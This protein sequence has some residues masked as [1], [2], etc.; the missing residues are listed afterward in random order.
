MA[1]D[2]EPRL[3]VARVGTLVITHHRQAP[4]LAYARRECAYLQ[5]LLAQIGRPAT[6][7]TLPDRVLPLV[8][9]EVLEVYRKPAEDTPIAAWAAVVPGVMGFAASISLSIGA[10]VFARGTPM[11]VF[12]RLPAAIKWMAAQSDLEASPSEIEAVVEQLRG[13][14]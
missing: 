10:Q 11:R 8:S 13:A 2:G 6:I 12:Q 1:S 3:R 14:D 9:R 5:R 7:L 4:D